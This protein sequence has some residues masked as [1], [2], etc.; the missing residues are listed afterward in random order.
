MGERGGYLLGMRA[1]DHRCGG[2]RHVAEG[3]NLAFDLAHRVAGDGT[4][5]DGA[6]ERGAPRV[7]AR[8]AEAGREAR[9][10]IVQGAGHAGCILCVL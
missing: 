5:D 2:G 6:A 10:A 1:L 9:D 4:E 7:V 3:F 8:V